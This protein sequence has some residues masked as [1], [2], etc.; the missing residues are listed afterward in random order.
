MYCSIFLY[1]L[2]DV[3]IA[4]SKRIGC[5]KVSLECRDP[6]VQFYSQFG[7][8]LPNGQNYMEQRWF[9]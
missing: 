5:Y 2:L 7:F 3:L 9:D 4:L 6:M 8:N 1:S